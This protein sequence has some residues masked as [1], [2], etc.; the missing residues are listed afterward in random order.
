M[1]KTFL[2]I[3]M[4]LVFP[5]LV[6]ATNSF[7]PIEN[8]GETIYI[9]DYEEYEN[10]MNEVNQNEV[11]KQQYLNQLYEE[12]VAESNSSSLKLYQAKVVSINDPEVQY[13]QDKAT[14]LY[15]EGYYQNGTVE[16]INDEQ[17]EGITLTYMM[18]LTYDVY[19]NII[20]PEIKVGD[21]VNVS[22]MQVDEENIVAISPEPDTYVKRFPTMIVLSMIVLVVILSILGKHAVKLVLPLLLMIDLLLGVVG[23]LVMQGFNLWLLTFFAIILTII[24]ICVLKLGAN[25]KAVTAIIT[26]TIITVVLIPIHFAVDALLNFSGL[27]T[28]TFVMSGGVIPNIVGEEVIPLFNFHS[29]SV[30]ITLIIAFSLIALV[31]CKMAELYSDGKTQTEDAFNEESKSYVADM[32]FVATITLLATILPKYMLLLAKSYAV[33]HIIHSEMFLIEFVRILLVIVAMV[34]TIPT[35][36]LVSK[37]LED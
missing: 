4:L 24:A 14:G 5:S 36:M 22:F 2:L 6:S 9:K 23:P 20:L 11:N 21:I 30:G 7:E 13:T 3:L 8:S 33:E 12:I 29:L 32:S 27:T 17:L 19:G 28:E 1:K 31:A 18:C 25:S 16:I 34:L 15:S 10:L 26:T 37:F 35:T